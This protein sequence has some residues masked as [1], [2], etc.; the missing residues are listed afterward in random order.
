[1]RL[2]PHAR[3]ALA[4][5]SVCNLLP[6]MPTTCSAKLNDPGAPSGTMLL[7]YFKVCPSPI[8]CGRA[9]SAL[10]CTCATALRAARS[11]STVAFPSPSVRHRPLTRPSPASSGAPP[12]PKCPTSCVGNSAKKTFRGVMVGYPTHAPDYYVYNP[13]TRR[14]TT[15][16]HVVFQEHTR[17]SA[18]AS[19]LTRSSPTPQMTSLLKTPPHH[20]TLSTSHYPTLN[21]L[22]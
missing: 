10:L 13:E 16:V 2:R 17:A 3:C 9:L 8:P 22:L 1:L 11:V 20:P 6:P 5:A 15:S 4:W 19:P 7:R 18:R 21:P 12:S 14:I